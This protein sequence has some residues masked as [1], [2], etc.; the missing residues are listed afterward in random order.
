MAWNLHDYLNRHGVNEI[1]QWT[2]LLQS[3]QRKKL[4]A[5]LNMLMQAGTDLPPQLL[6]G[7][8]IPHIFKLKVQGNPKLRPLIC[9]GPIDNDA[10]FTL[11]VGAKEVQFNYEPNDAPERAV[12]N[13]EEIIQ[14]QS[15]RCPHERID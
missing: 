4:K 14:N 15:R 2:R 10:E 11:L 1:A 8:G 9:R 13:R 5:K 6:A 3:P 12:S 7:T